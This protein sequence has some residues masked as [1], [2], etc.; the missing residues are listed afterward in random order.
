MDGIDKTIKH[1]GSMSA[2]ARALKLSGYQVVQQWIANSRVPAE[3]CVRIEELTQGRIRCE[4]LNN[5]INWA[6]VRASATPAVHE[7]TGPPA[8]QH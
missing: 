6:V 1:F 4:E 8:T 5:R 7:G 2:L 3:H